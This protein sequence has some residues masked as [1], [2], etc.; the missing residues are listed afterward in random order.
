MRR[1][2]AMV[3]ALTTSD[4]PLPPECSGRGD[5]R[6]GPHS[7]PGLSSQ[8][9]GSRRRRLPGALA[10][11]RVLSQ[12][13]GGPRR[14]CAV[15]ASD[16]GSARTW[17]VSPAAPGRRA[18]AERCGPCAAA[19]D[20]RDDA[21]RPNRRRPSEVGPPGIEPGTRGLKGTLSLL[22]TTSTSNNRLAYRLR[23]RTTRGIR[24]W[25]APRF[26]PRRS[27]D[28]GPVN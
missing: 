24:R 2:L 7:P 28:V 15:C 6:S 14:W 3:G 21:V 9:A 1:G 26:A 22:G 8:H 13:G 5:G 20:N 17:G 25:F 18:H 16:A 23:S 27:H 10:D 11:L 4:C 12:P 19:L